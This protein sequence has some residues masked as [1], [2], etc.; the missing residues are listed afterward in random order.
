MPRA[1]KYVNNKDLY[2]DL[3]IYK[4][5]VYKAREENAP[6][7]QVS[8]YVG[9][10]IILIAENMAK[11]GNFSGYSY[12]DEMILEAIENCLKYLHNFN[13]LHPTKN[14]FAYISQIVYNAFVRKIK[15]EK[16]EVVGKAKTFERMIIFNEGLGAAP[17]DLQFF[18]E[19][20][21]TDVNNN[22]IANNSPKKAKPKKAA[23]KK[24]VKKK[25]SIKKFC[26]A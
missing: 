16:K 17:E 6:L 9:K 23:K 14:P 22:I 4:T 7:P 3:L 18:Q 11:K 25:N 12:K 2:A 19:F 15:T 21:N 13:E 10:C 24:V 5:L 1:R 20:Y 26:G 8:E